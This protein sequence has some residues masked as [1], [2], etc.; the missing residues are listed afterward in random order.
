MRFVFVVLASVWLSA[1]VDAADPIPLTVVSFSAAD[2][3]HGRRW[4]KFEQEIREQLGNQVELA[5]LTSG[6]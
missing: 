5:M 3:A 2:S 6:Q 1:P 4:V